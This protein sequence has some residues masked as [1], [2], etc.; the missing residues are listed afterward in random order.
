VLVADDGEDWY[1]KGLEFYNNGKYED[2]I[3][4][5]DKEGIF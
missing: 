1:G 4:Y 3:E 2:A 5:F